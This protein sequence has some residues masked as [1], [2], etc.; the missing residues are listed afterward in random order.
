MPAILTFEHGASVF[1]VE[2]GTAE[3]KELV[4]G[5]A[6]LVSRDDP[7]SDSGDAG[8]EAGYEVLTVDELRLQAAERGIDVPGGAKKA[9]LVA[10]LE[11]DDAE[12]GA[13]GDELE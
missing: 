8:G 6:L 5:G 9:D 1:E 11:D 2:E 12:P 3:H 10:L 7:D 4:K 13:G